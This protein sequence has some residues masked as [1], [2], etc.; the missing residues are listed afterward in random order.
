MP[1]V[2]FK[3][4]L[5]VLVTAAVITFWCD[6]VYEIM[7]NRKLVYFFDRNNIFTDKRA[8]KVLRE[9]EEVK[10]A[11]AWFDRTEKTLLREETEEAGE[12]CAYE[13]INE[14]SSDKWAVLVHGYANV[15]R[16]ISHIAKNYY[17][18]GYNILMPCLHGQGDDKHKYV[19]MGYYDKFVV[20]HWC[21]YITKKNPAATIALHGVSMGGATV[22]LSTGESLP[23]NVKFCVSDCAYATSKGVFDGFMR[24]FAFFMTDPI[25]SA[26]N[27]ISKV[28]KNFDFDKCRPVDAVKK[29]H[30]PTLFIH[31]EEDHFVSFDNMKVLFDTCKAEKDSVSIPGAPHSICCLVD[32]EKY[33]QKVWSFEESIIGNNR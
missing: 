33:W 22:L 1:L 13:I 20:R 5:I 4:A 24:S 25:L 6:M 27:L 7:L 30:T 29:S 8:M 14:N 3:I 18:H 12:T 16:G 10:S 21:E 31:G 23:E 32:S 26:V 9:S 28:R 19:S 2:A 15:P 17:E 11:Q